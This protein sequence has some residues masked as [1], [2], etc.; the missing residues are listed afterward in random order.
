MIAPVL[1]EGARAVDVYFPEASWFDFYTGDRVSVS[2]KKRFVEVPA[3]L[4]VIPLFIRG[5]YILPTQFPARTT[6]LSRQNPFSL[7]IALDEQGEASG[8]LFWDDGDSIDSIEREEYFYVEYQFSNKVLKATVVK[9]GYRGIATLAYDTIQVLGFTSKPNVVF[10]N[11][12]T[13]PSNRI[14]YSSNGVR[15][16]HY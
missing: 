10:L 5:G 14:Q 3:P 1:E 7:I 8:S 11:G 6:E 16:T 4:D 13:I 15:V 9:N 12:Q 2:W